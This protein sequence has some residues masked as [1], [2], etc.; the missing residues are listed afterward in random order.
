MSLTGLSSVRATEGTTDTPRCSSI[1]PSWA[2][3]WQR[4][5]RTR[6]GD[7]FADRFGLGTDAMYPGWDELFAA[8]KLADYAIITTGDTHHV[9]PALL[10]LAAG[11]HVLLEKPMALDEA[12]CMRIVDAAEAADRTVAVCHVFRHSHV[13]AALGEIVA[14]GELEDVTSIQLSENVA[15]WHYAH[16][17]VRGTPASGCPGCCRSPATTSTCSSGSQ[18]RRPP[19]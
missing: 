14:S 8:G 4:Q 2:A 5:I 10:A 13:F 7:R 9:E 3:S 18:D 12:D 16:S 17:Y 11:Y 6:R 19:R 15:F 1:D